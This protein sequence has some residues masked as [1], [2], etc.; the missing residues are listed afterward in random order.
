MITTIL[1]FIAGSIAGILVTLNNTRKLRSAV[2][3]LETEAQ[4]LREKVETQ[5]RT[6]KKKVTKKK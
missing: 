4:E 1:T 5:V 6:V 2:D 3:T